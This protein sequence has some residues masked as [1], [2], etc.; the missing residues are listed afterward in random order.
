MKRNNKSIIRVLFSLLMIFI[1]IT[2][3]ILTNNYETPISILFKSIG[4]ALIVT[5]SISAFQEWVI[6]PIGI[7]ELKNENE[8]LKEDIKNIAEKNDECF[9]RIFG[10]L[11]G[12]GM[13]MLAPIRRG[14]PIYHKWLLE[15]YPQNI[16]ISGHSVLHRVQAD[17]INLGLID[18]AEGLKQKL[19]EGSNIRIL[20]LD[21][22]WD[23]LPIIAKDEGQET[24]NIMSDLATTLGICRKLWGL[25]EKEK[26]SGDIEIFTSKDL[27]L[28]AIHHIKCKERNTDEMLVGL[29][30]SHR[31]GTNSPLFKVE[32]EQIQGYFEEHFN[33]IFQNSNKILKFT[34]SGMKD[35]DFTYYRNCK[36][37]LSKYLENQILEELCP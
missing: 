30:F 23:L 5:G 28:Y 22:T 17:F 35:F 6:T 37:E 31:L 11:R 16:S 36:E 21:P 19:S 13:Y 15:K 18:V 26:Y 10:L 4:L 24:V 12:P 32:N 2:L 9:D 33:T 25:I 14:H 7:D 1:G 34:R 29:Y 27:K 3:T 8:K 20:F